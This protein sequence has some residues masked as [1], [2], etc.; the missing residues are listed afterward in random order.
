M[1]F[2]KS[3]FVFCVC[4]GRYYWIFVKRHTFPVT[5][6]EFIFVAQDVGASSLKF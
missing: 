4:W 1:V 5:K 2:A 3:A 6:C